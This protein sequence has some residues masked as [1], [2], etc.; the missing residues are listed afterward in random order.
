MCSHQGFSI[1][2]KKSISM[3][4]ANF[5][6]TASFLY[7]LDTFQHNILRDEI[8]SSLPQI[9]YV[10]AITVSQFSKTFH[11]MI[12]ANFTTLPHLHIYMYILKNKLKVL[13]ILKVYFSYTVFCAKCIISIL[14]PPPHHLL[15]KKISCVCHQ[16]VS[17]FKS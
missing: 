11:F 2:T 15:P 10:Y 8:M 7:F 14:T 12:S 9:S 5:S 1:Y 4:F 3:A 6:N 16:G 13:Y 17:F